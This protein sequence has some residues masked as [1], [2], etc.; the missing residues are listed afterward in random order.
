[1][2]G[3]SG[4]SWKGLA[5]VTLSIVHAQGTCSCSCTAYHVRPPPD[6][7][8]YLQECRVQQ[9]SGKPVRV[10]S[11]SNSKQVF[12]DVEEEPPPRFNLCPVPLVLSLGATG[13]SLFLLPSH[14]PFRYLYTLRTSI[15]SLLFYRQKS[16]SSLHLSSYRRHS[17]SFVF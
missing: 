4:V 13:N 7:F 5:E 6:R 11:H 3:Q 12:P 8:E 16:L 2:R 15:H 1:M 10:L 9:L 17:S 14:P